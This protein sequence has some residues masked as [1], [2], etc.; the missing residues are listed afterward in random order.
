[1]EKDLVDLSLSI[2]WSDGFFEV[3]DIPEVE[4]FVFTTSGQVFGVGGNGNGVDLSVVGLEGVSDLEVGVPDF[5]SSVPTDWG[6]VGLE[7]GGGLGLQLRRVS[8]LGDPVLVVIA[9]SGVFVFSQGVPKFDFFVSSGGDDLSV[10]TWKTYSE[11][12]LLVS[13]ELSDGLSSLDVPESQGLVPWGGDTE[14]SGQREGKVRDEVV[15]SGE[16]S[17]GSSDNSV[18]SFSVEVPG[19]ESF[20]S[21]SGNK[22]GGFLTVDHA[23]GG[24]E[25]CDPVVVSNEVSEVLE[26]LGLSFYH[27]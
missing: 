25:T 23:G 2:N 7:V 8:D 18:N 11:N 3:S 19:H 27:I 17:L 26:I 13:G 24:L 22:E 16:L 14:F 15:V 5:E 1:M 12:F 20:V 21:G 9:I 6:E 10:V 4:E